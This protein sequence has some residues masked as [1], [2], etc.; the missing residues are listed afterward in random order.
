MSNDSKL[1]LG[2]QTTT[3][4]GRGPR[5]RPKTIGE[6]ATKQ[7]V[8]VTK[9]RWVVRKNLRKPPNEQKAENVVIDDSPK[10][11]EEVEKQRRQK[12]V[13]EAEQRRIAA[14]EQASVQAHPTEA[15]AANEDETAH[16]EQVITEELAAHAES[17][18]AAA[19]S[20]DL[21]VDDSEVP[22]KQPVDETHQRQIAEELLEATKAQEKIR[23]EQPSKQ[24]L[25]TPAEP[26]A[27]PAWNKVGAKAAAEKAAQ[28]KIAEAASTAAAATT[29]TATTLRRTKPAEVGA[30]TRK[31]EEEAAPARKNKLSM[32]RPGPRT[33][34]RRKLTKLTISRAL[35]QADDGFVESQG[36]SMAAIKRAREKELMQTQAH[37]KSGKKVIRDVSIHEGISISDLASRMAEKVPDVIR[38]AIQLGGE[39]RQGHDTIDTDTAWLLVE[40]FGHRPVRIK[41]AESIET[42]LLPVDAPSDL[43]ARPPVI[44]VMGHVDH[45]KTTLL[46]TLRKTN[47]AAGE[48]GAITQHIGA[49]QVTLPEGPVLTFLDTPGHAAFS[50]M[51]ARGSQAT[52]IVVLVV[53]ADDGVQ[54]QTVEALKHAEAAGAPVVLAINKIDL[55]EADPSRITTELLEHGLVT[56]EHGGDV[57]AIGISAKHGTNL[58]KLLEALGLQAELLELTAN[59][60]RVANGVVLEVAQQLGKGVVATVLVQGGTLERGDHFVVGEKYGRVR[61]MIDESGKSL[62]KAGPSLPVEVMGLQGFPEVGDRLLVTKLEQDARLLVDAR[63][64]QRQQQEAERFDGG[65]SI[66]RMFQSIKAGETTEVVLVI[67]GDTQGSVEAISRAITSRTYPDIE[68]KILLSKVGGITE[69]DVLLASNSGGVLIGFNVR[70]N[71]QARDQAKKS[72]TQIMS[73]SLIY[74]LL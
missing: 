22:T 25:P 68:I 9:K 51:R 26:Q 5:S 24:K 57:L 39:V 14:A 65:N 67:K 43:V 53:A 71:T 38:R 31:P 11:A 54:P 3:P 2:N 19:D 55:P 23:K 44:T 29:A 32:N 41:N 12:A 72:N 61:N 73:Y 20:S 17:P 49:Y 42:Q 59:P 74:E 66:E 27:L 6:N 16:D 8:Q 40:E 37:L 15:T 36:R 28:E 7:T 50:Q 63:I 52:D 35:D 62:T 47:V 33:E 69:N 34:D 48:A 18:D 10:T 21:I 13:I 60:H 70:P 1:S 64:N 46:D 45:G 56:E 58:D 30:K 4:A